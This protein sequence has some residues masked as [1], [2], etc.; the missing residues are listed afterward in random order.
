MFSRF[1]VFH[2]C[3]EKFSLKTSFDQKNYYVQQV[4]QIPLMQ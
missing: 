2:S 1:M 3:S 4:Q